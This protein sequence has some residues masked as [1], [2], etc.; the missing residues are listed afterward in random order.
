VEIFLP[1]QLFLDKSYS[2]YNKGLVQS[3]SLSCLV[4]I[5]VYI[6]YLQEIHS[7]IESQSCFLLLSFDT[8]FVIIVISSLSLLSSTSNC[9][10]CT[11]FEFRVLILIVSFIL[12]IDGYFD[13]EV[14]LIFEYSKSIMHT[15]C[16]LSRFLFFS[17]FVGVVGRYR[18]VYI[19]IFIYL[20]IS[21]PTC[22]RKPAYC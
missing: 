8:S 10:Q 12:N 1:P 18:N 15:F 11:V 4:N 2:D 21:K 14:Y 9:Y 19:Y 5:V 7:I 22:Y 20:Y 17:T 6:L 13:I 3:L 16:Y